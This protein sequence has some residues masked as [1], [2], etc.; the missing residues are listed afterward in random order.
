MIDWVS[1]V[2]TTLLANDWKYLVIL[3]SGLVEG[4]PIIGSLYP[5]GTISFLIG[6]YAEAGAFSPWVAMILLIAG[7]FT[8]DMFGYYLGR[9]GQ[10]FSM[11]KNVLEKE[12]FSSAWD[13][14]ERRLFYFVVLGR[15]IPVVRS[16]P[17]LLA[18]ARQIPVKRY[19]WYSLGGSAL[20][21]FAGTWGGFLLRDILGK[22][23]WMVIVGATVVVVI[24]G[25]AKRYYKK[26]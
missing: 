22:N 17:S 21:G 11:I 19:V 25:I 3:L 13:I 12:K 6:T 23:A 9:Y 10:R 5:G 24:F 20:W 4:A 7:N 26:G 8:G 18:G 16:I 2:I 1:N 14:F 15:L